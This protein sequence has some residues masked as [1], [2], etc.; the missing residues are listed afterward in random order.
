MNLKHLYDAKNYFNDIKNFIIPRIRKEIYDE[1]VEHL[2]EQIELSLNTNDT[3]MFDFDVNVEIEEKAKYYSKLHKSGNGK[4]ITILDVVLIYDM[5]NFI[6]S[7]D[8]THTDILAGTIRL[9]SDTSPDQPTSF[10]NFIQEPEHSYILQS[11]LKSLCKISDN[12]TNSFFNFIQD[13]SPV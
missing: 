8:E 10:Y 7:A 11:E 5:I 3:S 13:Q 1:R 6:K 12:N 9:L 2:I 4:E